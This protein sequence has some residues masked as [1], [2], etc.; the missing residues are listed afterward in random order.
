MD[1]FTTT[2]RVV[3]RLLFP[4]RCALQAVTRMTLAGVSLLE[5]GGVGS[6]AVSIVDD[7]WHNATTMDT[8][9]CITADI[10]ACSLTLDT[11]VY[12]TTP[13]RRMSAVQTITVHELL[14]AHRHE[15][16][17]TQGPSILQSARGSECPEGAVLCLILRWS[18]HILHRPV[19]R[20][21]QGSSVVLVRP[22]AWQAAPHTRRFQTIVIGGDVFQVTRISAGAKI[23]TLLGASRSTLHRSKS[24]FLACIDSDGLSTPCSWESSTSTSHVAASLLEK[25]HHMPPAFSWP[26]EKR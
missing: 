18:H 2:P 14:F 8:G 23:G 25:R 13:P 9:C 20:R 21:C 22:E 17:R 12:Q 10:T 15:T 26:R 1:L 6:H 16:A 7:N 5:H 24:T 11:S 19:H 4:S 3:V